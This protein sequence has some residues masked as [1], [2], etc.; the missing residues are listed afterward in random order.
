[1]VILIPWH[2]RVDNAVD[3]ASKP[4]PITDK[5]I[6]VQKKENW[7]WL[8]SSKVWSWS[9]NQNPPMRS[10]LTV[11]RPIIG[12]Q[13]KCGDCCSINIWS[14]LT[15]AGHVVI[16]WLSKTWRRSWVWS[17]EIKS[18]NK[19]SSDVGGL[20]GPADIAMNTTT[21]LTVNGSCKRQQLET[22]QG[23]LNTDHLPLKVNLEF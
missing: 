20:T 1:M 3:Q 15:L 10:L 19:R 18:K 14:Q 8:R 13:E 16:M 17:P 7:P 2:S 5:T 11:F 21:Q 22:D 23:N 6:T 9:L 4:M 12:E